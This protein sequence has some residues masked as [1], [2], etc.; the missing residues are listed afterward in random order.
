MISQRDIGLEKH[1]EKSSKNMP[2]KKKIKRFK[3]VSNKP[4]WIESKDGTFT[5]I[6]ETKKS[7]AAKNSN[8]FENNNNKVILEKYLCLKKSFS[9]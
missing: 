5:L 8:Y 4:E 2:S 9:K 6:V 7:I 1:K 3:N